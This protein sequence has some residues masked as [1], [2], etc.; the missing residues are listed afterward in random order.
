MTRQLDSQTNK[1]TNHHTGAN[2]TNITVTNN[3]TNKTKQYNALARD[4]SNNANV[5]KYHE[6]LPGAYYSWADKTN[7]K[8]KT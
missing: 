6:T 7:Y 1:Q 8:I 4:L 3:H 2:H 5:K